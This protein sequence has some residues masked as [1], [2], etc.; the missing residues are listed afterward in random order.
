M[1]ERV[2]NVI[3]ADHKKARQAGQEP[4]PSSPK[5]QKKEKFSLIRRYPISSYE[6]GDC[7]TIEKHNQKILEELSKA[8]PRDTLLLP[9]LKATFGVR[10]MYVMNEATC[11]IDCLNKYPALSRAAVVSG[12]SVLVMWCAYMYNVECAIFRNNTVGIP[13]KGAFPVPLFFTL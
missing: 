9:L 4:T 10:R 5:R 11:V 2:R 8:K 1:V 7:A 13:C 6:V 3:K 12:L